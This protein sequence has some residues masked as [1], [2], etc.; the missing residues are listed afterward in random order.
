M[1]VNFESK[2]PYY[3]VDYL[4]VYVIV[5][6]EA[7]LTAS[8]FTGDEKSVKMASDVVKTSLSI[9]LSKISGERVSVKNLEPEIPRIIE[10]AKEAIEK[11]IVTVES[12][13]IESIKIA[14]ES[15]QHIQMVDRSKQVQTMSPEE[16]NALSQK[17]MQ[18]AMAQAAAQ[19]PA[20]GQ[21][22]TATQSPISGQI[23]TAMPYPKFCP[24]CGTPTTGGNFCGE[25]GN[26]LK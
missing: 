2:V 16:I 7:D 12:L 10:G 3:D 6:G 22:P 21:I 19:S 9:P 25:C 11:N 5:K 13:T 15:E 18:E 26:K 17:A 20:A 24:N 4:Q 23:P 1:K 14:P 8:F